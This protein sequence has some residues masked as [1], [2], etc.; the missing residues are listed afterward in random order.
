MLNARSP[1]QGGT[2]LVQK[3][4]NEIITNKVKINSIS[5][6]LPYNYTIHDIAELCFGFN[7]QI[8][9]GHINKEGN[10]IIISTHYLN[11]ITEFTKQDYL[12][13]IEQ[14]LNLRQYNQI[15]NI[16]ICIIQKAHLEGERISTNKTQ[17]FYN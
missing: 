16:I 9:D 5:V 7:S 13:Q 15:I 4:S 12:T 6:L 2:N 3:V 17:H 14:K 10:L 11:L 1:S 8:I